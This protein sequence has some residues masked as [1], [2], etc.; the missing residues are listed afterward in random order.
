VQQPAVTQVQLG[1]W[2]GLTQGQISRIEKDARPVTDLARLER[3]AIALHIPP[4]LLWFTF[5]QSSAACLSSPSAI[6]VEAS[7]TENGG[8]VDRR[9]ALR[10]LAGTA[11]GVGAAL[12]KDSPWQRL[13]ETM[14]HGRPADAIT[15]SLLED[16]TADFFRDEETIP[17]RQLLRS[18]CQH[19]ETIRTLALNT[20]NAQ[21]KQRLII[22]AGETDAL[23]GWLLFDMQRHSDAVRV[24]R[25]AV[26][27]AREVGDRPLLACVLGYW[28]Y[29]LSSQND[30]VGALHLLSDATS[31]VRGSAAATQSWIA[32][33]QAEESAA[34]HNDQDALYALDRALTVF[35]Y[36]SP[37]TE[38]VWTAFFSASRLGS[39][40][41][42]A[43]SRIDHPETDIMAQSLLASLSP[44][45]NKVRAV[46]L[47][48][49]ASSAAAHS[50]FDRAGSLANDAAPLAVRTEASLATDRLWALVDALPH[51]A[52]GSI[53]ATRQRLIDQL[54]APASRP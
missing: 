8:D 3:W 22:T 28:S 5:S 18:L 24:W 36:A 41:V 39:M 46:V 23:A 49:L 12:I 27:T 50:D 29:L 13:V 44:T 14:E 1:A 47:A 32:A 16:R 31:Q 45:E 40:T 34:L 4:R 20:A 6:S 21:L 26:D 52:G 51:Q 35:D 37:R 17:A 54:S 48:E 7:A 38:R 19:R 42:S 9:D 15:V 43:Y 30:P 25:R 53:A 2:L 33:R 11:A 10:A